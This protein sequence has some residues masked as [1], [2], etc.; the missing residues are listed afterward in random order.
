MISLKGGFR[1]PHYTVDALIAAVALRYDL[2]LLTADQD[3]T[4][5]SP[6]KQE[7]WLY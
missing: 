6:L 5:I 4:A 1:M 2:T 3:F 7:N